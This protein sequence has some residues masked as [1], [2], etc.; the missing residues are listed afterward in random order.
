MWL[1]SII[2]PFVGGTDRA[3]AAKSV[4]GTDL[5]ALGMLANRPESGLVRGLSPIR[6][7]F[8]VVS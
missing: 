3:G 8:S 5:K 1:A 7:I 2:G 6:A 4:G